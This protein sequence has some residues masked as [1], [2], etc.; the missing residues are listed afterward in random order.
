MESQKYTNEELT[1]LISY[2]RS[3]PEKSYRH[4]LALQYKRLG[5]GSQEY[6]SQ[7]FK[8]C[9]KTIRK[10]CKE[11]DS[12]EEFDYRQQRKPGGSRK[13]KV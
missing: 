8:C 6:I 11:L 4:F 13:K 3:L 5:R 10:G 9:R 12:G 1:S 7:V 2:S